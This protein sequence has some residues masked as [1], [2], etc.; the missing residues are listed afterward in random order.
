MISARRSKYSYGTRI[1][2]KWTDEDDKRLASN[3]D[4]HLIKMSVDGK[5][6][7]LDIF[8]VF[9]KRN[10]LVPTDKIVEHTFS[11]LQLSQEKVGFEMLRSEKE[12]VEYSSESTVEKISEVVVSLPEEWQQMSHIKSSHDMKLTA[13]MKFGTDVYFEAMEMM[14]HTSEKTTFPFEVIDQRFCSMK[15]K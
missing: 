14:N 3:K 15:E 4:K 13:K 11:P 1:S 6:Y 2:R 8:F 12:D 10:H 5:L 9:L 7:A